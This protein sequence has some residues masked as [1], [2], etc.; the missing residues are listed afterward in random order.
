[1]KTKE[2]IEEV[3]IFVNDKLVKEFRTNEIVF[4]GECD[5]II[6]E[7]IDLQNGQNEIL[8]SVN[9]DKNNYKETR[10]INYR[11]IQ[12]KYYALVISVQDYDY[13]ADL[14]N[15]IS[16]GQKLID[17]L[18]KEYTFEPENIIFLKNPTKAEIISTLHKMRSYIST[19]DNL[20]IFYAGHGY[21]DEG[22]K[23]GYWLPRDSE[24]DNPVNWF[25]NTD[26][27]NYLSA[28]KTKH[29][30]LIADACFSGGIFKTRKA[31]NE[32][33]VIERLY[34]LPSR[35]AITSGT[36]KEVPDESV[37]I[38]FLL[39]RLQSNKNKYMTTEELCSSLRTAV[40]NNSSNI[41]QF[42]TI[43]NTGDE[44]GDFIFIR[45]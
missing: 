21:W 37:F 28:I 39:K 26:L 43:K 10:V 41:P 7:M 17:I 6:D 9:T 11:F 13:I 38:E 3:S 45:R 18:V 4:R 1:V 12:A 30:L 27:T 29:T 20:L 42:G 33:Q 8:I 35:K 44:G 34:Q 22:M 23:V 16:D 2:K 15:P 14:S 40:M 31:F 19:E 32:K 24:Q 5:F 25:S 36:L